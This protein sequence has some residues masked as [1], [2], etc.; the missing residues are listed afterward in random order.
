MLV[1]GRGKVGLLSVQSLGVLQS[2]ATKRVLSVQCGARYSETQ[3]S[4][5]A[6]I[7]DVD[8]DVIAVTCS[9]NSNSVIVT[10]SV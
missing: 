8:V 7:S 3:R 6:S 1:S 2:W 10:C 5:Q 9:G 4:K